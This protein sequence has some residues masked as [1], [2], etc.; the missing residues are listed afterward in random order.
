[1]SQISGSDPSL[2]NAARKMSSA[3]GGDLQ[4]MF[5]KASVGTSSVVSISVNSQS[6]Q[7]AVTGGRPDAQA[8]SDLIAGD[9]VVLRKIQDISTLSAHAAASEQSTAT[10]QT[11]QSAVRA[12]NIGNVVSDYSARFNDSR[13]ASGVSMTPIGRPGSTPAQVRVASAYSSVANSPGGGG[14]VSLTFTG[15]EVHV[16][17]DGR[18]WV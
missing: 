3:L 6:G 5:R 14:N 12:A 1:M 10:N 16:D 9:P 2:A 13:A 11:R 4:S 15:T 8:I 7:V 18:R 17:V